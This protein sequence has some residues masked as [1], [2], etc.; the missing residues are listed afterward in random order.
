MD[1]LSID[2]GTYSVKFVRGVLERRQIRFLDSHEERLFDSSKDFH[3]TMPLRERQIETVKS[4]WD[5]NDKSK[6][7]FQVPNSLLTSR[8]LTLPTSRQKQVVMMIP[9][10]LEEKLP[11]PV[12]QSHHILWI[13]KKKEKSHVAIS[14]VQKDDFQDYYN[15]LGEMEV[16]P[17]VLTSELFIMNCCLEN[18]PLTGSV[19]ILDLGHE[20]TKAYFVHNGML[21]SNQ[22]SCIGGKIIDEA[23]SQTYGIDLEESS[24]YKH[25]NCF[26]LTSDQYENIS[27][28][29]KEFAELMERI[30]TPLVQKYRRWE[31]GYRIHYGEKIDT[32]Y[33][34]GGTSKINNISNFLTESLGVKVEYFPE[35]GRLKKEE[36][37]FSLAR[38]MCLS[39]RGKRVLPNFLYGEYSGK[40][41][42]DVFLH[43][44]G[45]I[46]SRTLSASVIV[47]IFL[48]LE[49]LIFIHPAI[50]KQ[51]RVNRKLFKDSQI[52]LGSRERRNYRKKPDKILKILQRDFKEIE[53]EVTTVLSSASINAASSLSLLS[54]Y[55]NKNNEVELVEFESNGE[56]NLAVFKS[57]KKDALK[58]LEQHL[59]G[60]ALPRKKIK[61]QKDDNALTLTFGKKK[62]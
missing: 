7:I 54:S 51:D 60:L 62:Q 48:L 29:Q 6:V 27:Q 18:N 12:A 19:A 32:V 45:F 59:K 15:L 24:D 30:F 11:F 55:L 56:K 14:I 4:Y 61:N 43:S 40:I 57:K 53:Q 52:A 31:L 5:E 39:Q 10:Q 36:K 9:F 8:Y 16:L 21:V 22:T 34:M 3:P 17:S 35:F 41:S 1:I 26:F 47:V 50:S 38:L 2:I 13:D 37:V 42:D 44:T 25:K 58:K 33:I 28:E 23:I 20:T 49:R 46:L